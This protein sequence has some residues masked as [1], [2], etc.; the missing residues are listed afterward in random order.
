MKK[1][2]VRKRAIRKKE[3]LEESSPKFQKGAKKTN[4]SKRQLKRLE[5]QRLAS[6]WRK[7]SS[8]GAETCL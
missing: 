2:L 1:P 6:Y 7:K 4:Q 8:K 3:S 5:V